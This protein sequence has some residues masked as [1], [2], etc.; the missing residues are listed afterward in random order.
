MAQ[1]RVQSGELLEFVEANRPI[2]AAIR[3]LQ[4]ADVEKLGTLLEVVEVIGSPCY[5]DTA[6]VIRLAGAARASASAEG[7]LA[8]PLR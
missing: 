1:Y 6:Y 3:A 2:E 4:G 8:V 5:V 7:G